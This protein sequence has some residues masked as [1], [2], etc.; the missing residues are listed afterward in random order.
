M[1]DIGIKIV[2]SPKDRLLGTDVSPTPE[3]DNENEVDP[4]SIDEDAK[5][6][7]V[8]VDFKKESEE[9]CDENAKEE[10]VN[11][12]Q[13]TESDSLQP[14]VKGIGF[15]NQKHLIKHSVNTKIFTNYENLY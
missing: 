8:I 10:P 15:N 12:S 5:D 9:N 6:P 11:Q 2:E 1:N 4:L 3:V 14:T 13:N 7:L